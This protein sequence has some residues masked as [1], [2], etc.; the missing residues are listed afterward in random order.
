[1]LEPEKF[2]ISLLPV[3][4]IEEFSKHMYQYFSRSG[5][6][7]NIIYE[8]HHPGYSHSSFAQIKDRILVRLNT[9]LESI[10]WGRSFIVTK[11]NEIIGHLSL[12]GANIETSLHRCSLGMG[13]DKEY[14]GNGL[15]MRLLKFATEWLKS[16]T[17]IDWL[18]LFTFSHNVAALALYKKYGFLELGITHDKYR[19]D[20]EI[21]GDIQMALRIAR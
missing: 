20:G 18:D 21:I 7:V 12:R 16:E 2:K 13:V 14:R 8:A 3:D 4:K 15:G 19:I 5:L 17:N 6:D 10:N 11:E 9:N 1:M